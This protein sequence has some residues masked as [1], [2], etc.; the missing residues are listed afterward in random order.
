M[1]EH[2]YPPPSA[3]PEPKDWGHLPDGQLV[4]CN[5][6]YTCF[7]EETIQQQRAEYAATLERWK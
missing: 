4:V 1:A 5:Y 2:R 6:G 3:E 7:T